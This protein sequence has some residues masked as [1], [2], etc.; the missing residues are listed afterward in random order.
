MSMS[1]QQAVS[2]YRLDRWAAPS[3]R[4]TSLDFQQESQDTAVYAVGSRGS[5]DKK[6]VHSS[7]V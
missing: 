1:Q 6:I 7:L 3:I 5:T 2:V 4:L